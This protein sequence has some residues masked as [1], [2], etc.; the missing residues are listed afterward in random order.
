M[1][2]PSCFSGMLFLLSPLPFSSSFLSFSFFFFFLS[3]A[4]FSFFFFLTTSSP[5]RRRPSVLVSIPLYFL[6]FYNPTSQPSPFLFPLSQR[7]SRSLCRCWNAKISRETRRY[8]RIMN[9]NNKGLGVYI[10]AGYGKG[11]SR[12]LSFK[13]WHRMEAHEWSRVFNY[14]QGEVNLS[15]FLWS[16]ALFFVTSFLPRDLILLASHFATL[17][18]F[19]PWTSGFLHSLPL[20]FF[21]YKLVCL[22]H[23]PVALAS[24]FPLG[25]SFSLSISSCH[26][27][28]Y[29]PRFSSFVFFPFRREAYQ[30]RKWREKEIQ[31]EDSRTCIGK[32]RAMK[33]REVKRN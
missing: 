16:R 24:N 20:L 28:L 5:F 2:I 8:W 25:N 3:F 29:F 1:Q 33:K 31:K 15:I 21:S 19:L 18:V 23:S 12:P 27:F 30:K 10:N 13:V 32:K 6:F 17:I 26:L 11:M 9:G 4:S 7:K 22:I 14:T